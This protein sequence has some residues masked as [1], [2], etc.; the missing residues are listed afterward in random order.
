M[1]SV[2]ELLRPPRDAAANGH[3][4]LRRNL[5][6]HPIVMMILIIAVAAALLTSRQLRRHSYCTKPRSVL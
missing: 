2:Q 3:A 6:P 4:A 1:S 5:M